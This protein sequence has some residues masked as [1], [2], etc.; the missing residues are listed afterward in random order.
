MFCFAGGL[1]VCP[2]LSTPGI[3]G[4]NTSFHQPWGMIVKSGSVWL[5]RRKF[6]YRVLLYGHIISD[7]LQQ[8]LFQVPW[9]CSP[10]GGS[11]C[12][13]SQLWC[14]ALARGMYPAAK[15]WRE[16]GEKGRTS[17]FQPNW[18]PGH[19]TVQLQPHLCPWFG[20]D[21]VGCLSSKR[22][23]AKCWSHSC[24]HRSS[25]ASCAQKRSLGIHS[26][27]YTRAVILKVP[28]S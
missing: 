19:F 14:R 5:S 6:F 24:C 25:K 17:A 2:C 13:Y 8:L 28:G 16:N 21:N 27:K 22:Q 20:R 26:C 4:T 23:R 11:L 10:A 15:Q 7:S 1:G 3:H 18:T 12:S 9:W